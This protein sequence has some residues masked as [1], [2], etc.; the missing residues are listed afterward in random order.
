M[1][2]TNYLNGMRRRAVVSGVGK[3]TAP[4]CLGGYV[5]L[6][7]AEGRGQ[8]WFSAALGRSQ[9][10]PAVRRSADHG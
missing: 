7:S 3:T 2:A 8:A 6:F 5:C 10:V 1:S 9:D 4:L